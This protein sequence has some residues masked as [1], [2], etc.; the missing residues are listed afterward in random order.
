MGVV[1]RW[2]PYSSQR[3]FWISSPSTMIVGWHNRT[4]VSWCYPLLQ[5]GV[6]VT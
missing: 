2:R 4:V 3:L 5:R 1:S 6:M